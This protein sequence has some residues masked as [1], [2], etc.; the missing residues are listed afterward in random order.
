MKKNTYFVEEIYFGFQIIIML[1]LLNI[2]FPLFG[3]ND[4]LAMKVL[5]V[6]YVLVIAYRFYHILLH[7]SDNQLIL[8]DVNH[9]M[10]VGFI[11]GLF[12]FAYVVISIESSMKLNNLVII[13][14]L[15]QSIRMQNKKPY[16]SL[17]MGCLTVAFIDTHTGSTT[18]NLMSIMSDIVLLFFIDWIIGIV[19]KELFRL[20]EENDFYLGELE[21][22]NEK[23]GQL[24]STDYL[25]GLYNHKSFYLTICEMNRNDNEN[26]ESICMALID[27]DNFKQVN[28]SYGHLAGDEILIKLSEL[29]RRSVRKED[30]IARYG[31][32]EF[33][34]LFSELSLED[35][36]KLCERLRKN[37]EEEVFLVD[38]KS[39][40]ITISTGLSYV[41]TI[42]E[43]KVHS[44]VK[45]VDELLY[46]A[47]NNGKNKVVS[48]MFST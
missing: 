40:R 39:L 36:E 2:G 10:L 1:I 6:A 38:N 11:D 47:K 4:D 46:V 23:L 26:R 28:D 7:S 20:Q 15:I 13:Y 33:V 5:S 41:E 18:M 3:S 22:T 31:G 21:E 16:V 44:F 48:S 43:K 8:H 17:F 25:T 42:E 30:F 34:I 32:E 12:L 29:M 24:A 45:A 35:A 27:I 9:K 14:V 19:F 37:V